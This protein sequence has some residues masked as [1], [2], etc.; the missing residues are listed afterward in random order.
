[1]ALLLVKVVAHVAATFAS[2]AV[3]ISVSRAAR[4]HVTSGETSM[5]ILG[6]LLACTQFAAM[7]L[8]Y[9]GY[10]QDGGPAL[11]PPISLANHYTWLRRGATWAAFSLLAGGMHAWTL[12]TMP[13]NPMQYD[14][15]FVVAAIAYLPSAGLV[16]LAG[17]PVP[18][19]DYTTKVVAKGTDVQ[20]MVPASL[21]HVA[22]RLAPRNEAVIRC[23]MAAHLGG[24]FVLLSVP[25]VGA[26]LRTAWTSKLCACVALALFLPRC[27]RKLPI[28]RLATALLD[29]KVME[30]TPKGAA[31][32]NELNAP[33]RGDKWKV[34]NRLGVG[35]HVLLN[36]LMLVIFSLQRHEEVR[37][38]VGWAARALALGWN[39]GFASVAGRWWLQRL[40]AAAAKC[41]GGPSGSSSSFNGTA[42]NQHGRAS[43]Q[44]QQQR[45][46]RSPPVRFG[47]RL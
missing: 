30:T 21:S 45:R 40:L 32:T 14:P 18:L 23:L 1:M 6:L 19:R 37:G 35:E 7:L 38:P 16:L 8:P 25:L 9:V 47:Q 20:W 34:V 28:Y 4:Q 44:R 22:L 10:H 31:W 41:S 11:F 46:A 17:N 15:A 26:I 5:D 12:L 33:R 42:V 13:G 36:A 43:S 2:C 39:V 3:A 29:S 24:A 27:Q